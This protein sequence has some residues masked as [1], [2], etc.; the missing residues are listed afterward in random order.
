VTASEP[1]TIGATIRATWSV[2]GT[3]GVTVPPNANSSGAR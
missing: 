2:T 3:G 1:V